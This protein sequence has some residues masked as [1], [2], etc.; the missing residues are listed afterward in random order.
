MSHLNSNTTDT[1]TNSNTNR[2]I[3]SLDNIKKI[4]NTNSITNRKANGMSEDD[5]DVE[6]DALMEQYF[7]LLKRD[8]NF[9]VGILVDQTCELIETVFDLQEFLLDCGFSKGDF[10]EWKEKKDMRSYH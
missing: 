6:V 3:S 9:D 5:G 1:D 4:K 8:K 10:V 2:N 7:E